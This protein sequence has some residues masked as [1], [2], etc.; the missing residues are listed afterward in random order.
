MAEDNEM[1]MVNRRLKNQ[2]EILLKQLRDAVVRPEKEKVTEESI[3][4][5]L[6]S[7]DIAMLNGVPVGRRSTDS[8][9]HRYRL[10]EC[11][12]LYDPSRL[13]EVESLLESYRGVEETL[14]QS[15]EMK[16]ALDISPSIEERM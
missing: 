6:S 3:A 14:F 15:L 1:R 7:S 2:N 9:D 11:F 13:S 8:T 10:T 12:K 5:T 4:Y 16:Y